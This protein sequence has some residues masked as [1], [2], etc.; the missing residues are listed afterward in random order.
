[1]DESIT[2]ALPTYR[3]EKFR[4]PSATERA[5][6]LWVDRIGMGVATSPPPG[7]RILG[8]YCYIQIL[9]GCGV[10]VSKTAGEWAVSE[11]DCMVQFPE[12][13]CLY[14]PS[15]AWTTCWVTWNGPEGRTLE[16]AGFMSLKRPVFANPAGSVQKAY[17]GLLPM[18]HD[19]GHASALR[20][21]AIAL[22]MVEETFTATQAAN[23]HQRDDTLMQ[24]AVSLI[25]AHHRGYTAMPDLA[26]ELNLST[27]HFRRLFRAYT[28]KS[29]TEFL[30]SLR[31]AEAKR[32]LRE[33]VPIKQVAPAVGFQDIFY[34]MRVFRKAVG[35][36][37]GRFVRTTETAPNRA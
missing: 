19:E 27:T 15:G 20:R 5:I 24:R 14:Y 6:G 22:H 34:F 25:H 18:M 33:G 16:D 32:L 31:M 11:G 37:P 26:R 21:K 3:E 23:A 1:M 36:P 2:P 12:D 28:G 17:T 13:P 30:L 7:L 10:Y 9:K 4:A 8:Q 35:V 29:P